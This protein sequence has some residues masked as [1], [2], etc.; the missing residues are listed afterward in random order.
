MA[1]QPLTRTATK[2]IPVP[3][4]TIACQD[5]LQESE[6]FCGFL[7]IPP[8]FRFI[9]SSSNDACSKDKKKLSQLGHFV[10]NTV[11]KMADWRQVYI[12][13]S[14][15]CVYHFNDEKAKKPFAAYSL[16]GYDKVTTAGD[17]PQSETPWP[18]KIIHAKKDENAEK[19]RYYSAPSERE[20][21]EWMLNFKR[22]MVSASGH[23]RETGVGQDHV[24]PSADEWR[25]QLEEPIYNSSSEISSTSTHNLEEDDSDEENYTKI[26]DE[27]LD[28]VFH[29]EP[30]DKHKPFSAISMPKFLKKTKPGVTPPP[31]IGE[32][33]SLP[34]SPQ[35]TETPPSKPNRMISP[36]SPK[37]TQS[38]IT[39][40]IKA[41][42]FRDQP[43][44]EDE[45]RQHK[46]VEKKPALKP[47]PPLKPPI[48]ARTLE[49]EPMAG[50]HLKPSDI[51]KGRKHSTDTEKPKE[52]EYLGLRE[53]VEGEEELIMEEPKPEESNNDNEG[54][55]ESYWSAVY[56]YGA[57][58][59]EA[60]QL[61][62]NIGIKG[63]YLVRKG[64][65][66]QW[67]L[68]VYTGDDTSDVKKY[69]IQECADEFHIETGCTFQSI[70]HMLSHYYSHS[71]PNSEVTL[72]HHYKMYS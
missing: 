23:F 8:R 34:R 36:L 42:G 68:V 28:D 52:A 13:L 16:Y 39:D 26:K 25:D 6:N 5:L 29:K 11:S 35:H 10:G 27:D 17:I 32:I 63:V 38:Q 67:V 14:K 4:K 57:S 56:W 65:E 71:L 37:V 12:V 72:S 20:S 40:K 66:T 2:Q 62:K 21:K 15:G 31:G 3:H 70:P 47:K 48:G 33:N 69:K 58:R 46:P 53:E 30:R 43:D 64:T 19:S 50:G 49:F 41:L 51:K 44:G 59:E 60:N 1:A 9:N 18:F 45:S 61:I 24:L 54:E 55:S 7:R 22:E